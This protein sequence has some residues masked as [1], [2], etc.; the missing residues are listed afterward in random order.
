MSV[1]KF[2]KGEQTA[3]GQPLYRVDIPDDF[4]ALC[5]RVGCKRAGCPYAHV[6]NL[7]VRGQ[8]CNVIGGNGTV[9]C[10]RPHGVYNNNTVP[11]ATAVEAD[12]AKAE[13]ASPPTK[14]KVDSTPKAKSAPKADRAKAEVASPATKPKVD[15][16]PKAKSA[17][18][19]DRAEDEVASP[20]TKPKGESAPKADRAKRVNPSV[21]WDDAKEV[22]S[23]ARRLFVRNDVLQPFVRRCLEADHKIAPYCEAVAEIAAC[24][25]R[26][27]DRVGFKG[28]YKNALLLL[29]ADLAF[30]TAP[31][32]T[33][34]VSP[35]VDN[36]SQPEND[37][38]SPEQPKHDSNNTKQPDQVTAEGGEVAELEESFASCS[39]VDAQSITLQDG[40]AE[41][42][43]CESTLFE[44]RAEAVRLKRPKKVPSKPSSKV[45][46]TKVTH[47]S[48]AAHASENRE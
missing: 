2:L 17:P 21:K 27:T 34:V 12:R 37:Q 30:A 40:C 9:K 13:V 42:D 32:D 6:K 4:P 8:L 19:A 38:T 16:T 46:P 44:R 36:P 14:P 41:E 1:L 15:S 28:K 43:V 33:N 39:I 35:P 10:T 25:K 22:T 48:D 11:A 31:L 3:G 23:A 26:V 5:N 24:M 47:D 7:C 18:K 20:A 29:A 45:H